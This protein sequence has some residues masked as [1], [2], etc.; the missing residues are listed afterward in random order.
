MALQ[1]TNTLG[2]RR[3]PFEP[4]EEGRVGIYS[5]GPTVYGPSHVGNFRSF[6][7]ADLLRRHLAW[8]GYQVT[9]VMN[10]TDVDDRI[11]REA[12]ARGVPIAE[13]TAKHIEAFV[14]DL[15]MLRIGPPD[16]MPRA[17]EHIPEMSELITGRSSPCGTSS[18][19]CGCSGA[20]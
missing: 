14:R 19:V 17:T 1:L 12:N 9:W 11:I 16:I 7:F 20:A 15:A 4:V 13:L 3:E 8:S 6:V 2:G 10:I 18:R 5:C